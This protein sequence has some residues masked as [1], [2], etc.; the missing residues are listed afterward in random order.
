MMTLYLN[1][2]TRRF[3]QVRSANVHV[4][5]DVSANGEEYVLRAYLPGLKA[6]DVQ[7]EVLEN[8]ITIQGEF[9]N[10]ILDENEQVLLSELPSGR[11]ER[12]LRLPS[13]LDAERAQAEMHDGVLTLHVAKA[14]H[15][16]SKKI[17]VLAK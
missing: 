3:S 11:F 13:D 17:A 10:Q 1:P 6:E 7:I 5:V 9:A 14:E 2:R 12:T 15:A 4:P 16:K 8:T